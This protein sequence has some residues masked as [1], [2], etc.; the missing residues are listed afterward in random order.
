MRIKSVIQFL[1][2][3]LLAFSLLTIVAC[4]GEEQAEERAV[5]ETTPPPPPPPPPVVKKRT[6]VKPAVKEETPEEFE[7]IEEDEVETVDEVQFIPH[8]FSYT[9]IEVKEEPLHVNMKAFDT[10]PS[11]GKKCEDD[12]SDKFITIWD[13]MEDRGLRKLRGVR[14]R[15]EGRDNS[16]NTWI[17]DYTSYDEAVGIHYHTSSESDDESS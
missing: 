16:V 12:P 10:A 4:G 1:S 6:E 9:E 7:A 15:I 13:Y 14:R 2:I 3:G 11:Y 8:R 5:E 17:P